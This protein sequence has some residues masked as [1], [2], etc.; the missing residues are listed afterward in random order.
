MPAAGAWSR[1]VREKAGRGVPRPLPRTP[2]SDRDRLV[3]GMPNIKIVRS[4]HT[5][6]LPV[7]DRA[8]DVIFVVAGDNKASIVHEL[9][10]AQKCRFKYPVELFQ[11]KSRIVLCL[12]D[13]LLEVQCQPSLYSEI[14]RGWKRVSFDNPSKL[15]C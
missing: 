11:P 13:N 6:T 12:G 4:T 1:L 15:I 3:S 14:Q 9:F 10:K 7:L 8:F 2:V 5:M